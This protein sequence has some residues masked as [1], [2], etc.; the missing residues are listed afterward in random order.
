MP[1]VEKKNSLFDYYNPRARSLNTLM[2]TTG[3]SVQPHGALPLH[4]M[5]S[6]GAVGGDI[7]ESNAYITDDEHVTLI[8]ADSFQVRDHGV[9]PADV[10][11]CLVGK[12]V[13]TP[14]ELQGANLQ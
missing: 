11:H 1:R 7:N 6:T 12:P 5:H 3:I 8:D 10:Y 2:L 13:Y 14:P 4:S 9:S